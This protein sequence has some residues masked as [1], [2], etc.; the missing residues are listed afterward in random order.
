MAKA[1]AEGLLEGVI[2]LLHRLETGVAVQF[3]GDQPGKKVEHAQHAGIVQRVGMRVDGTEGAEEAAVR[4]HDGHGDVALEAVFERRRMQAEIRALRDIVDG[5]GVMM[6]ADL[7]ADGGADLQFVARGQAE[8]DIVLAGQADPAVIGD[9]GDGGEAQAGGA[10]DHFQDGG[11][12]RNG[13]DGVQI[14]LEI[15]RH[16]GAFGKEKGPA[17]LRPAGPLVMVASVPKPVRI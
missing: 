12:R 11:D 16:G 5:D 8:C 15:V 10:A 4:H 2:L 14:V 13:G 9:A 7:V 3:M 17:K 1:G 6:L